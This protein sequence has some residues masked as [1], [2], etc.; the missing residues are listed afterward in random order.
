[1][2]VITFAGAAVVICALILVLRQQK[3]EIAL[4][5][6]ICAGIVMA[7]VLADSLIPAVESIYDIVSDCGAGEYISVVLKGL[8]ICLVAGTAADICRDAGQQT[9]ATHVETAGRIAILIAA[10][11]LLSAVLTTAAEI[12]KG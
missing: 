1:M 12:I 10:L 3:P 6:T 2:D 9:V 11:P 8:G 7:G 4:T 5:V